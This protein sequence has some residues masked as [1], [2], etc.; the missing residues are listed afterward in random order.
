MFQHLTEPCRVDIVIAVRHQLHDV[1]LVGREDLIYRI[2]ERR[3]YIGIGHLLVLV[4]ADM[5]DDRLL[6]FRRGE[7][8]PYL[9]VLRVLERY[10]HDL[11][12]LVRDRTDVLYHH[13]HH[14]VID[15]R[16]TVVTL[17]R[18]GHIP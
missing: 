11:R 15:V 4:I 12:A 10:H 17:H 18:K 5:L 16:R 9:A 14:L 8:T 3:R 7:L 1:D 6:A 13:I 2:L